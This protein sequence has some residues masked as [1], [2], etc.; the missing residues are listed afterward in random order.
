MNTLTKSQQATLRINL[1][2]TCWCT[3]KHA[4]CSEQHTVAWGMPAFYCDGECRRLDWKR[5]KNECQ[6]HV[7]N[8]YVHVLMIRT[9]CHWRWM[10]AS[11]SCWRWWHSF[12]NC[13]SIIIIRWQLDKSELFASWSGE[14]A[15][16]K[17]DWARHPS[18]VKYQSA[19]AYAKERITAV[20]DL[21]QRQ[22]VDSMCTFYSESKR[23]ALEWKMGSWHVSFKHY[24]HLRQRGTFAAFSSS[25]AQMKSWKRVLSTYACGFTGMRA[26]KLSVIK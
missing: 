22:V 19:L 23:I 11:S 14:I 1:R 21:S 5:H 20:T 10:F 15:K 2:R 16:S 12:L 6:I 25:K 7:A 8:H 18:A 24:Q 17:V 3:F 26:Q 13:V 4:N 9:I